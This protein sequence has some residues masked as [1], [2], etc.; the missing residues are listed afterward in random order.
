MAFNSKTIAT[1]IRDNLI[2]GGHDDFEPSSLLLLLKT[3][4]SQQTDDPIAA[5]SKWT[6]PVDDN[7][8]SEP[9]NDNN[10]SD[11]SSEVDGG[12][13]E[14]EDFCDFVPGAI[15]SELLWPAS[16]FKVE[17]IDQYVGPIIKTED[18][19]CELK[20]EEE[21]YF[22]LQNEQEED[23]EKSPPKSIV[24]KKKPPITAKPPKVW[25]CTECGRQFQHH[26]TYLRHLPTHTDIRDFVCKICGK[27]F[28]QLSTLSQHQV[29]HSKNRPFNCDVCHKDFN[30]ISTLISHRKTHSTVKNFQCHIC[31]KGFHQK[32]NLR[33]HV[34]IHS[35][36]RPYRC[37]LCPKGFNQMSNLVCHTQKTHSVDVAAAAAAAWQCSSCAE[38]F[39]KRSQL[40]AH[41]LA[42]HQIM[43]NNDKNIVK[44]ELDIGQTVDAPNLSESNEI[45]QTIQPE[46]VIR[47]HIPILV[48][49]AVVFC[50]PSSTVASTF[51]NQFHSSS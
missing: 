28:R 36:E 4:S 9:L 37:T 22:L 17:V 20:S 32:G 3:S 5:N 13:E 35:N 46:P 19:E 14:E 29:I 12:R 1:R 23:D 25:D 44:N 30:R 40:R 15:S 48:Y 26:Y 10:C 11:I 49:P 18:E 47:Y 38:S 39:S 16:S 6:K 2:G 24:S 43:E 51:P 41:E 7:R 34:Y 27:A 31:L 42:K 21:T 50:I 8:I 45:L 33:N